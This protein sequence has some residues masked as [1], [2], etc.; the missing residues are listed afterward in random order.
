MMTNPNPDAKA[1]RKW[2]ARELAQRWVHTPFH[3][4]HDI[5]MELGVPVDYALFGSDGGSIHFLYKLKDA[6]KLDA[7]WE[8]I[9]PTT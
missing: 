9:K 4:K 1:P 7:L 2:D 8:L 6:N 3:R 5:A